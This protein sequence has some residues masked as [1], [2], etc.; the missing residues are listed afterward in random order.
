MTDTSWAN[1]I[2]LVTLSFDYK[3]TRY[4]LALGERE[5]TDTFKV[6]LDIQFNTMKKKKTFFKQRT[7]VKRKA[8]SRYGSSTT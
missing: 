7:R 1:F 3:I 4:A 2:H 5:R 8:Y 6:E